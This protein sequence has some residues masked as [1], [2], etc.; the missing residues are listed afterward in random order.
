L[1]TWRSGSS[2]DCKHFRNDELETHGE[3]D[4]TP[5]FIEE[6]FLQGAIYIKEVTL[7]CL[8]RES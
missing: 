5:A 4:T 3:K 8:L 6:G 7:T 2:L 1:R